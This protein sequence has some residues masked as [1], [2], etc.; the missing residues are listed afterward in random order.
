MSKKLKNSTV[1]ITRQ[2][3]TKRDPGEETVEEETIAVHEFVT[4]PAEVEVGVALTLNLGNFE[5]AK[6]NVNVRVPCYKEELD[7]AYLFAQSF[8]ESRV[9]KERDQI[10]AAKSGTQSPL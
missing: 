7:A 3:G 2:M 8:V 6:L 9:S 1:T 5:S 10:R 4:T